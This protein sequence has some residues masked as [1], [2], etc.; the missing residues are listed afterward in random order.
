L[1]FNMFILQCK[2]TNF[3]LLCFVYTQVQNLFKQIVCNLKLYAE[4]VS[5]VL[6]SDMRTW[7]ISCVFTIVY[8]ILHFTH[9]HISSTVLLH[10]TYNRL[11]YILYACVQIMSCNVQFHNI[12]FF[13]ALYII[14][15]NNKS[16]VTYKY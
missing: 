8:N 2:E 16:Y 12:T 3:F 5:S 9:M 4:H 10:I 15:Y 6:I 11:S 7:H 14:L 1:L 13:N